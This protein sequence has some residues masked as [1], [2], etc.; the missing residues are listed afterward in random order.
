VARTVGLA[1]E[2]AFTTPVARRDKPGASLAVVPGDCELDVKAPAKASEVKKID[3]VPLK[4][5]APFS[6]RQSSSIH[7]PDRHWGLVSRIGSSFDLCAHFMVIHCGRPVTK[8][9]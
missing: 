5:R 7:F 6:A 1:P 3:T 8:F 4:L 9:H 2:Q